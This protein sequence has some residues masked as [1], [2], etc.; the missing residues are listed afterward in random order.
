V[1]RRPQLQFHA[2]SVAC[3]TIIITNY[4]YGRF[5]SRSIDSALAQT[6]SSTQVIVVD[7]GSTDNSREVLREYS[8]RVHA[9]LLPHNQGQA[10]AFNA[11]FQISHGDIVF[12]LD[13]DDWLYPHAVAHVLEVMSPGVALTQF[14]LHLVDGDGHTIDLLPSPEV[15][16][17]SGNVLP[18]L[19]LRGRYENTVTSGNAFARRTLASI[20]PVPEDAF[21]ISADGY[22]LTLAPFCGQIASIEQPLGAYT[23]HGTNYWAAAAGHVAVP[24]RF[25]RALLH[26]TERYKALKRWAVEHGMAAAEC[27]G[28]ADPQHLT[29]RIGSLVMDP[30]RHPDPADTRLHLAFW[31]AWASCFARLAG[32]RRALLVIWFLALG[33]LPRRSA[34]KLILWRLEPETRPNR[35][36]RAMK[37]VR[38]WM[39]GRARNV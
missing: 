16:F 38:R 36:K 1:G 18:I 17:D 39:L 28:L 5:L 22:L 23:V 32:P 7:D 19:L 27:P 35:V 31:G 24:S 4:N 20:L 33:I 13:A 2:M 26:D 14:R 29:N 37:A 10:A 11:G 9:V 6:F 3:V 15:S 12:F 30:E 21:R 25:R 8:E 34:E